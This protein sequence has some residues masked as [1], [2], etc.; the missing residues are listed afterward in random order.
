M[1]EITLLGIDLAKN[2]FQLKGLDKHHKELFK[3]RLTRGKLESF[4]RSLPSCTIMMEA[5][6]GSNHWGRTF[7]AMG[8]ETKLISPQHVTPYVGN[9]KNDYKDTDGILECGSRPRTKFVSVKTLEQQD[10]QSLLRVRERCVSNRVSLSNQIRGLLL[11][12]GIDIA[13]GFS[14]L[15]ERIVALLDENN[16]QLSTSM[17]E[18]LHD[19][20]EEFKELGKRIDAYD[21]KLE[22][23]SNEQEHCKLLRTIPGVGPVSAVALYAAI[24]NG[25]QFKNGRE[26]AAHIGLVPKQH[27]SGERQLLLGIIHGG[28]KH[29]KQLLI[30]GA[31]SVL[32]HASKKTDWRSSWIN[33]LLQKKHKNTVAAAVANRTARIVWAV[34]HTAK[35]YQTHDTELTQGG[36][37]YP[38][39]CHAPHI[40]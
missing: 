20:Y 40:I 29:L 5:C 21:K 2:V 16:E 24:G 26:L 39:P 13:T 33:K 36:A 11:E 32:S 25:S 14:R 6:G 8:H 10:M 35:P 28:D 4:V 37:C 30:H 3:K 12:Y 23:I 34:L 7:N 31:R 27:S 1:N 22:R 9:H 17:K 15:K 18:V 38:Q 19:C